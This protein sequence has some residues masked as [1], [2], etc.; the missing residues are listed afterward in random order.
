MRTI[1]REDMPIVSTALTGRSSTSQGAPVSMRVHTMTKSDNALRASRL[2]DKEMEIVNSIRDSG[3]INFDQL[4]KVVA[5]VAPALFDPGIAADDY[6]ATGYS[7]VIRI[8]KTG[9][10]FGGL[11]AMVALKNMA[12]EMRE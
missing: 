2:S 5:Q 9:I 10:D 1:S 6:I 4:G 8:W 11:E 12:N 7:S 3:V